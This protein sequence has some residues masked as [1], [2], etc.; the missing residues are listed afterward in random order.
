MT[1]GRAVGW[2]RLVVGQM[3]N[4]GRGW[5]RLKLEGGNFRAKDRATRGGAGVPRDSKSGRV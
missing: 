3:A 2:G 4:H 5:G 1:L